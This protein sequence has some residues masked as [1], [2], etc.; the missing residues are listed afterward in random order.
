MVKEALVKPED[1]LDYTMERINTNFSNYSSWH[2]RSKLLPL[3]FPS[4]DGGTGI[5]EEKR[6]EEL[7]LIQ[8][9]AFTDPDDSSAWFYHTWLLGGDVSNAEKSEILAFEVHPDHGLLVVV[10]RAASYNKIQISVDGSILENLTW[11]PVKPSPAKLAN[12]WKV[13]SFPTNPSMSMISVQVE[14]IALSADLKKGHVFASS[15]PISVLKQCSTKDAKTREVLMQDLQNCQE[16]LELEPD[17]KWTRL[18]MV[19]VMKSLDEK[20]YLS[21]ILTNL[22]NLQTVD[23]KRKCYYR[24]MRSKLVVKEKLNNSIPNGELKLSGLGLTSISWPFCLSFVISLDLS[25][26]KIRS[27][28]F[29]P[30]LQRCKEIICDNNEIR[31]IKGLPKDTMLKKFSL[32]DN[33]ISKDAV[34]K[35]FQAEFPGVTFVF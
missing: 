17:S 6:R 3:C 26:N 19:L 28:S 34:E 22:E 14:D 21:Q 9:A 20:K 29:L 2:L 11:I 25:N 13:E 1:E 32:K 16:L 23:D 4:V 33:P 31:E 24:D 30:Y 5:S 8:N 12:I 10:S 35:S 27:T 7:D 15:S 18:S